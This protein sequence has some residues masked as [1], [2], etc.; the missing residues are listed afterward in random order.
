MTIL[1][2]EGQVE[3]ARDCEVEGGEAYIC[4]NKVGGGKWQEELGFKG[5]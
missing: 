1:T 5:K 3:V 4:V 2:F